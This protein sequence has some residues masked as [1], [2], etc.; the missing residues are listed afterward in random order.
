MFDG[1]QESIGAECILLPPSIVHEGEQSN[2]ATNASGTHEALRKGMK[3]WG[4]G[5]AIDESINRG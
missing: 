4:H 5:E 2:H 1:I 3:F